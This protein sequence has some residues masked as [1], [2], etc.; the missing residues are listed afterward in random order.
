MLLSFYLYG[1]FYGPFYMVVQLSVTE[2]KPN[3]TKGKPL[4]KEMWK[5]IK[6]VEKILLL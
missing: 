4:E 6:K 5:E 3:I 2:D 1:S